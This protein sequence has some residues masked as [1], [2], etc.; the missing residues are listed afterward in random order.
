MLRVYGEG[1]GLHHHCI[2]GTMHSTSQERIMYANLRRR[3]LLK[4]RNYQIHRN[5][6]CHQ[7]SKVYFLENKP[8]LFLGEDEVHL[9]VA[10]LIA[11]KGRLRSTG[12][13]SIDRARTT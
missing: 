12:L 11:R 4:Q 6:Y 5:G 9:V 7:Y 10:I 8:T 3:I 2:K 13:P 1:L